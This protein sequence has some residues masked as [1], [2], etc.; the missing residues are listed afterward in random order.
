MI[1]TRDIFDKLNKQFLKIVTAVAKGDAVFPLTIPAN[2]SL[3]GTSYSEL[4]AALVPL[5]QQ[6]KSE[7]GKGYSVEW[8][9][10]LID[11]SRQ[12]IPAKIYVETFEDFLYC[13]K[14]T[15]DYSRIQEAQ[16]KFYVE[17]P[18][19]KEWTKENPAFFLTHAEILPDLIK[20]CK[21]FEQHQP[22]HNLFI[23]ELPVEVHSKFIED[24]G[25]P[26]KKILDMILPADWID[27]DENDFQARYYIK[28][29][30]VYTQ[31][32]ILDDSL[33]T[34]LGFNELALTLDDSALLN[35][36]PERVFIIEN[37]ACFLSFPKVKNAVAI[38]GEGFKSRMTRHIPWLS[39]AALYCWFD[40]DAAGFEMLNIIRQYYP[41]AASFLM[42]MQTFKAFERFSVR[43]VYRK[44][45]LTNLNKAESIMYGFLQ[46]NNK[47]LEQERITNQYIV[48]YLNALI[49]S[50]PIGN[51]SETT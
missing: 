32:R 19:L 20:V 29:P 4:K 15:K 1:T 40:M 38:F 24:N 28:K 44:L 3:A 50:D 33:K 22:P 45:P 49:A 16:E 26:L 31:I 6:S 23:R 42:N 41:H 35:W 39:N 9:E 43:S 48:A 36:L 18:Q 7:K 10:K 12:K 8:K 14:R 13:T 51:I 30:N 47:R 46:S 27:V 37:K 11:G 2:K 5:Y 17:F 34:V 21:Y 25:A